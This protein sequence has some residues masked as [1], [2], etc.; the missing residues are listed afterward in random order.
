MRVKKPLSSTLHF[1]LPIGVLL[2]GWEV[3][4][5]LQIM[6]PALISRPSEIF[7]IM[8]DLLNPFTESFL[9]HSILFDIYS[10]LYRLL[11]AFVIAALVGVSLGMLMGRSK[12][13]YRFLDPLIT[14]A[15][16]VPGIAWAPIF[17]FWLGFGDPT[18]IT[19]GALAAFFPILYNTAAGVRSVDKRLIW[20]AQSAGASQRTVFLKVFLPW[21][22]AYIFTGF[23]LALARG[24][25]TIIA[26]EMIA[27]TL[28]GLGYVIFDA[29]DYLRPSIVYA[30]IVILAVTYFLIENVIKW[31][32]KHTIEKWGMVRS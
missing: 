3:L 15:M 23:K 16:P 18:I 31:I 2:F 10:S 21:S 9:K 14:V 11:Y 27:A 7:W 32:E 8:L 6:N 19:V 30:G 5:R 1:I 12:L 26:V 22:A 17:M 28:L 4:S 13:I 20:S 29:R 24:W 25:R